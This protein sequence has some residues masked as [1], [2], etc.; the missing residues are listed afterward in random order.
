MATPETSTAPADAAPVAAAS[1]EAPVTP[2]ATPAPVSDIARAQQA[3]RLAA[4]KAKPTPAPAAPVLTRAQVLAELKAEYESDPEALLKTVAGED[5]RGMAARVAKKAEPPTPE[6]ALAS[7]A[8]RLKAVEDEKAEREAAKAAASQ[9][10]ASARTAAHVAEISKFIESTNDEGEHIYPTLATL[11]PSSVDED[12]ADT[13]YN[14]VAYAWQADCTQP[15][16]TFVHKT[17]DEAKTKAMFE[18]AFEGLEAHYAKI[19]TPKPR[20]ATAQ[21]SPSD[22]DPSPTISATRSRPAPTAAPPKSMTQEQAIRFYA[23]QLGVDPGI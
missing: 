10:E 20:S 3:K 4:A 19:R 17:W 6:Q 22:E 9:A 15:D 23:R 5:F 13:A 14:A 7:M 21:T 1:N 12:P 11:D 2:A 18:A 8:A 16:G